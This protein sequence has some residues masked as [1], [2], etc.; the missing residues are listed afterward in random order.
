MNAAGNE[1]GNETRRAWTI[2]SAAPALCVTLP[3]PTSSAHAKPARFLPM[4]GCAR[5]CSVSSS[6]CLCFLNMFLSRS[7]PSGFTGPFHH[8]YWNGAGT[9]EL[10]LG[11][12]Q[13]GGRWPASRGPQS[14]GGTLGGR[15]WCSPPPFAH[16]FNELPSAAT[17]PG[18]RQP[19][20][21]QDASAR[22]RWHSCRTLLVTSDSGFIRPAGAHAAGSPGMGTGYFIS[23]FPFSMS[24]IISP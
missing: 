24:S 19:G 8:P 18:W 23:I 3:P 21:T 10:G 17:W 9:A 2:F 6:V 14:S 11:L 4:E 22:V 7:S 13:R 5:S 16:V 15:L 1:P 12:G 20:I